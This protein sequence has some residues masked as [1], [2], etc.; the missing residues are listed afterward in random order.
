MPPEEAAAAVV[1]PE[2]PAAPPAP[3]AAES[4]PVVN[5]QPRVKRTGPTSTLPVGSVVPPGAAVQRRS[6][7]TQTTHKTEVPLT[8]PPQVRAEAEAAKEIEA[9][10]AETRAA[11]P[12]VESPVAEAVVET[13]PAVVTTEAEPT[14]TPGDFAARMARLERR[15]RKFAQERQAFAAERT[16]FESERAA[17]AQNLQ[18]VQMV[19]QGRQLASETPDVFLERVYGIP[20]H[21]T[22]QKILDASIGDAARTP[23]QVAAAQQTAQQ[24]EMALVKA[25]Q[26]AYDAE[27]KRVTHQAQLDKEAAQVQAY[28]Q[29][30]LAPLIDKFPFVKAEFGDQA[31]EQVYGRLNAV[32]RRTKVA[33]NPQ[34]ELE[35]AE[36][37]LREK[38]QRLTPL[39]GA[40]VTPK[41]AVPAAKATVPSVPRQADTQKTAAPVV[42]R[43]DAPKSYVS[44]KRA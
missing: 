21:V 5:V 18:R 17:H 32:Y 42:K 12:I 10:A 26:D 43:R 36:K 37:V 44:T 9:K 39:L 22:R 16:R 35:R 15:D 24:S 30:T 14:I 1:A 38:A 7:Q 23:E 40:S 20:R 27:L 25:R 3:A 13:P 11:E 4:T 41:Q 34:L 6:Y 33:P 19:D 28:K 2:A 31:V 29:T 8:A